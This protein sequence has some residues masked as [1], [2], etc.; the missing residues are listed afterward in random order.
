MREK[1]LGTHT[2]T[3]RERGRERKRERERERERRT[4]SWVS[5]EVGRMLEE[6]GEG[7]T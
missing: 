3:E 1:E 5:K 4:G 7:R 2:H 6:M